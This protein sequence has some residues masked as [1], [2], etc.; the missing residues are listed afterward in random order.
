MFVTG[1]GT[2]YL[3]PLLV[4]FSSLLFYSGSHTCRTT[5]RYFWNTAVNSVLL[6]RSSNHL[7]HRTLTALLPI[8][9]RDYRRSA[10]E[11]KFS[12]LKLNLNKTEVRLEGK[13]YHLEE[14]A[15][16][17][18]TSSKEGSVF[19]PSRDFT[20]SGLADILPGMKSVR[21][22]FSHPRWASRLLLW[23]SSQMLIWQ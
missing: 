5:R 8:C 17:M 6:S 15:K 12:W 22:K 14:L 18:T 9:L 20:A 4:N 1:N 13:G 10:S 16:A 3:G 7:S 23:T 11:L 21:N 2:S 19:W